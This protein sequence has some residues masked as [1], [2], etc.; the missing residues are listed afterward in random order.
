MML[1]LFKDILEVGVGLRR[2]IDHSA[3]SSGLFESLAKAF[4]GCFGFD[5]VATF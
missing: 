1:D 5:T 3:S 4:N 2:E